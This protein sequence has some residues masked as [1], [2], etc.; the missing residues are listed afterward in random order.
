M[1]AF[2]CGPLD[3]R[4]DAPAPLDAKLSQTL[5]LYDVRW[6]ERVTVTVR[7]ANGS[8]PIAPATGAYLQ[9]GRMN[10]DRRGSELVATTRSHA[11]ARSFDDQTRWQLD[12][13]DELVAEQRLEELEDLISLVVT[14]GWRKQGWVPLHGAAVVHDDRCAIVC[15]SSGGG[16]S[17]FTAALVRRGWRTLGDDKLLLRTDDGA[18]HL[19]ALL[20]TF[21]LHPR[22]RAW[23]PEVG[24]LEH[25]PRYSAW[26]EKRKV[27]SP[28]IWPDA[29]ALHAQPT[30]L[31]ALSRSD[32]HAGVRIS[33]LDTSAVRDALLRQTVFPRD[34]AVATHI[35]ATVTATASAVRGIAIEVGANAYADEAI[36]ATIATAIESA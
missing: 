23:F 15:A 33:R 7:A 10:V 14:T 30:T 4:V 11:F 18:P 35:F 27:R 13:P 36:G 3:V 2:A 21:N 31:V 19:A 9:C 34:R 16:K 22:T 8:A 6:P 26:T 32:A 24:A 29:T 28:E 20:H 5:S 25:L 1:T 17:S 12:V